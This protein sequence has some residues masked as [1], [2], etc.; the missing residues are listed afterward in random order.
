MN[1]TQLITSMNDRGIPTSPFMNYW[2]L[3]ELARYFTKYTT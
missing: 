1:H 3:C 2:D